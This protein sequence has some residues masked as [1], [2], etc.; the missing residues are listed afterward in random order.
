MPEGANSFHVLDTYASQGFHFGDPAFVVRSNKAGNSDGSGT[1][2]TSGGGNT[3]A[4]ALSADPPPASGQPSSLSVLVDQGFGSYFKAMAG[5]RQQSNVSIEAFDQDHH[6]IGQQ[7][8]NVAGST[9]GCDS[10]WVCNWS[11]LSIDLGEM[12][13]F[14]HHQRHGRPALAG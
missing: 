14:R 5:V 10:D 6:S 1:F 9:T 11:L 3:G 8:L 7:T 4:L 2:Y 13:A 12:R